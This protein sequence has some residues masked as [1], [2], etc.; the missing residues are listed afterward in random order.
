M[1]SCLWLYEEKVT[2]VINE[3]DREERSRIDQR[4]IGRRRIRRK[5][6]RKKKKRNKNNKVISIGSYEMKGTR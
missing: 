2:I 1:S 3:E 5:E 4:R 6:K